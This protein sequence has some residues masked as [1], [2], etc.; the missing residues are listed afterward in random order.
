[1]LQNYLKIPF[2]KHF[3]IFLSDPTLDGLCGIL[4]MCNIFW[5]VTNC[6]PMSYAVK[7]C[8][9]GFSVAAFFIVADVPV[10]VPTVRLC[11]SKNINV[12]V[13]D[14]PGIQPCSRRSI[15]SYVTE[16]KG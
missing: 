14:V 16:A 4:N 8:R 12:R 6:N 1:M 2:C 15:A 10:F 9:S 7:K 5:G 3:L 11:S 13:A